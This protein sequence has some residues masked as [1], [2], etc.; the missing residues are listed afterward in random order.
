MIDGSSVNCAKLP[1]LWEVDNGGIWNCVLCKNVTCC[2]AYWT[3]AGSEGNNDC[4][5]LFISVTVSLWH[6]LLFLS[7]Y[8]F[9]V[10]SGS[11]TVTFDN[12]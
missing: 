8:C 2:I 4:M 7:N 1:M 9:N 5:V 6:R 11:I 12:L 3:T 10:L